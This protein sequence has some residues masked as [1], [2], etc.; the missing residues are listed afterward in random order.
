MD[1]K[2]K[3]GVTHLLTKMRDNL[4]WLDALATAPTRYEDVTPE[5]CASMCKEHLTTVKDA[6]QDMQQILGIH[7]PSYRLIS[8]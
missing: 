5:E 7:V 4:L 6:M 2:D 8:S 3:E 1:T